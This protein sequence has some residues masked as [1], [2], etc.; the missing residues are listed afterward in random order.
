M[1]KIKN[2]NIKDAEPLQL[3]SQTPEIRGRS[4]PLPGPAL[5]LQPSDRRKPS[6][7][8][9]R[10]GPGCRADHRG[11]AHRAPG[12]AA[13]AGEWESSAEWAALRQADSPGCR[14]SGRAR[15]D[16]HAAHSQR[17][18]E[19]RLASELPQR[20]ES[21]GGK[22]PFSKFKSRRVESITKLLQR[23]NPPAS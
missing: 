1:G 23:C 4:R 3:P 6:S 2:A 20:R 10:R 19:R 9:L 21:G 5:P 7:L 18:N 14:A 11:L 15:T 13:R 17:D 16:G 12:P 22:T 8:R